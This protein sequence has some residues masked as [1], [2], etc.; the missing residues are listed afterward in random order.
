MLTY[1]DKI[2]RYTILGR[3]EQTTRK[4]P[5][6]FVKCDVCSEDT[7][8]Y[9]EPFKCDEYYLQK[10]K[11]V[12]GCYKNFVK[13]KEQH[14]ILIKRKDI[15]TFEYLPS[16]IT[17]NS[18][19]PVISTCKTCSYTYK[20][21]LG[22]LATKEKNCPSCEQKRI[23]K[24]RKGIS[25]K[26]SLVYGKGVNDSPTPIGATAKDKT[27]GKL[28]LTYSCKFY[29]CWVSMLER[30]YSEKFH[31]NHPTYKDCYVCDEWLIFSNFK[32]W[33]ETQDYEGKALDKDLLVYQNKVYSPETCVFIPKELNSFLV[34]NDVNRGDLPIGVTLASLIHGKYTPTDKFVA[35][36]GHTTTKNSK[37]TSVR[38][39]NFYTAVDAH[40]AWQAEKMRL[41][42]IHKNLNTN[43]LIIMGLQRV[44]DK[45]KFDYD[46]NLITEDF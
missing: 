20:T 34:K 5:M 41:V 15:V 19:L 17:A 42:L 46:N 40:R 12:C 1:G 2:G 26:R 7:E 9:P 22:A 3:V 33:M 45:I 23:A 24:E 8:L 13:T 44:Y 29:S 39:G 21:T 27:T 35:Y 43:P 4:Q 25:G 16:K 31:K 6:Y 18:K 30:C 38:L 32:S 14:E 10:G 28:K 11:L 36:C 37:R